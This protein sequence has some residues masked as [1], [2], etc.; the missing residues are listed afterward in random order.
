MRPL[1]K[2]PLV[3]GVFGVGR[4]E[5]LGAQAL[6]LPRGNI[7]H[8]S[9]SEAQPAIA[10]VVK[11]FVALTTRPLGSSPTTLQLFLPKSIPRTSTSIA[12]SSPRLPGH[13]G[14]EGAGHS[15][16]GASAHPSCYDAGEVKGR[17]RILVDGTQQ[18]L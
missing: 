15:I 5:R 10:V 4:E 17:K 3:W 2:L 9:R 6:P 1:V 11:R 14:G 8:L 13:G 18:I 16:K 12:S 7:D